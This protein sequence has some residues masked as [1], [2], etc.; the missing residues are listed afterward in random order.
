MKK[1]LIASLLLLAVVAMVT[2]QQT[3]APPEKKHFLVHLEPIRADFT[4][5]LTPEEAKVFGEHF[6]Y[7][8]KLT[9]EGK[10]LLAGPAFRQPRPFGVVVFEADTEAEVRALMENDPTVKAKINRLE[11]FPFNLSLMQGRTKE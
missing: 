7:L 3:P 8:K 11:I 5:E 1:L 4:G 2:A 9:L 6:L 10:I